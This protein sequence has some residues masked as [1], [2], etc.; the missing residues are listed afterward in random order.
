MKLPVR[1]LFLS[2]LSAGQLGKYPAETNSGKD[3][4]PH[5]RTLQKSRVVFRGNLGI[6]DVD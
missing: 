1:P 3:Y 4:E 5:F 6:P 2:A